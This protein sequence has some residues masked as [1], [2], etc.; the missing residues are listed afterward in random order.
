MNLPTRIFVSC[1]VLF[2]VLLTAGLIALAC[3]AQ[4]AAAVL[5]VCSAAP[6]GAGG[7]AGGVAYTERSYD[8]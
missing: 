5:I 6:F 7:V 1:V 8:Y 3:G 2:V 4:V